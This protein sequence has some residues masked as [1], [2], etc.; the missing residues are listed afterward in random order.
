M[1]ESKPKACAH[2][3]TVRYPIH[4]KGYC[5]DCYGL[6]RRKK[7]VEAWDWDDPATL[8]D[9]PPAHPRPREVPSKIPE[10]L[11]SD[12]HPADRDFETAVAPGVI[13]WIQAVRYGRGDPPKDVLACPDPL[14]AD[15]AGDPELSGLE[16]ALLFK[17][18]PRPAHKGGGL[19]QTVGL[20]EEELLQLRCL[21]VIEG[22]ELQMT[23]DGLLMLGDRRLPFAVEFD[24]PCIKP[25]LRRAEANKFLQ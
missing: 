21:G 11:H 22:A 18:L 9:Y 4:A 5:K 14:L 1:K 17:K 6:V 15:D 8:K 25:Q 16:H 12:P 10:D 24:Q 2:C 7:Q 23:G 13:K 3:R 20:L 19:F